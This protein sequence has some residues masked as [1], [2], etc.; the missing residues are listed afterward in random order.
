MVTMQDVAKRAGVSQSTVSHFVNGTRSIHPDTRRAIEAAIEETGYVHDSVASS[1]RTGRSNIIGLAITAISNPYFAALPHRIEERVAD[2]RQTVLLVDTADRADR[3]LEA[4]RQLLRHRPDA[5]LLAQARE[6][7]P[8]LELLLDRG[9]PTV[10]VD[11][12]PATVPPRVDAVG[13]ENRGPMREL[14]ELLVERGHRSIALLAGLEGIPTTTERIEGYRDAVA[15]IPGGPGPR[16]EHASLD[17]DETAAAVDALLGLAPRPTAVVG[18]NNQAT[19]AIMRWVREHG[20]D[21]PGDISVVGFDDFE[22]AELFRPR[23]TTVRQPIEEL[24]EATAS[25]L[26]SRME[27][28][29]QPTRIVRLQPHLMVRDSIATIG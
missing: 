20:L 26:K 8:A 14:V 21:V 12:V 22:W 5:I 11:R 6:A 24:A 29:D 9:V 23:L 27:D 19:I 13:V 2:L 28:P 16:I 1:L 25:L 10:L 15:A 3:E 4:V 18:G 17:P 7:S